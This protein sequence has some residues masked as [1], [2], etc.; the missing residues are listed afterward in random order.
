MESRLVSAARCVLLLIRR[1]FLLRLL[2]HIEHSVFSSLVSFLL[3]ILP[4]LR[5]RLAGVAS[6][7]L[8]YTYT[9]YDVLDCPHTHPQAIQLPL[10]SLVSLMA[11]S[12]RRS[13]PPPHIQPPHLPSFSSLSLLHSPPFAHFPVASASVLFVAGYFP[14][15]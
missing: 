7:L 9:A 3:L 4:L 5:L 6:A 12:L 15:H 13:L 11:F 14:S 8:L 1:R 10:S 2:Q